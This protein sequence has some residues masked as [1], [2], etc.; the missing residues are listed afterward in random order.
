[1]TEEEFVELKSTI[2]HSYIS[3]ACH[4]HAWVDDCKQC[5]GTGKAVLPFTE[6]FDFEQFK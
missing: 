3:L 1:M 6:I 4:D 5:Q 2:R